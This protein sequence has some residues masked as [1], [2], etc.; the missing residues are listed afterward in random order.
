MESRDTH[1]EVTANRPDIIIQ[2]KKEKTHPPVDRNVTQKAAGKKQLKYKSLCIEIQKMWNM[3]CMI[4]LVIIGAT[5]IVTKGLKEHMETIPGK[6]SIDA[7]QMTT[8]LGISHTKQE[9]LQSET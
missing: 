2:N 7:L 4:I 8:I 1:R 9:V 3:K 6:N 5:R